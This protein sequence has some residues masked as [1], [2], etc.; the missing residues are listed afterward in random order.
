[1]SCYSRDLWQVEATNSSKENQYL[2]S[3]N[4]KDSPTHT[5]YLYKVQT[6]G[7]QVEAIAPTWVKLFYEVIYKVQEES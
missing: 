3:S 7:W 4:R 1:M 2:A 6:F 5:S